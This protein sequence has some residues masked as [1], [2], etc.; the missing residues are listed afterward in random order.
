MKTL[1]ALVLLQ[2]ACGA[3]LGATPVPVT[4]YA[5]RV[6]GEIRPI[7]NYFGY[8]EALPQPPDF[9][10]RSIAEAADVILQSK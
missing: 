3:A 8:D 2:L 10:V 7:W 9:T 5:D 4:V 6:L 1:S